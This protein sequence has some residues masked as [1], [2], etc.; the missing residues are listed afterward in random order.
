[1]QWGARPEPLEIVRAKRF[2]SQLAVWA[3]RHTN[4][5]TENTFCKLSIDD[6]APGEHNSARHALINT[7]PS[8]LTKFMLTAVVSQEA[9]HKQ[10]GKSL[11][12]TVCGA[13][14]HISIGGSD[15][16]RRQ[17]VIFHWQI[18]LSGASVGNLPLS[19]LILRGANG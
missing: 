15:P 7:I 5:N 16:Q 10:L 14:E 6:H 13:V 17:W 12:Q 4:A 11:A 9:R 8:R 19:A 1:M 18:C 2:S 3:L